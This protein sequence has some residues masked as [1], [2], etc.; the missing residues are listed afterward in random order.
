MSLR[1]KH[2]DLLKDKYK[3]LAGDKKAKV[4]ELLKAYGNGHIFKVVTL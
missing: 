1:K 3:D 2:L 4:D